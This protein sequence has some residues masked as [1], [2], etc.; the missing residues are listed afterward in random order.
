MRIVEIV[1]T[2]VWLISMNLLLSF[3]V[4]VAS[5]SVPIG[6]LLH[7]RVC[8]RVMTILI[9]GVTLEVLRFVAGVHNMSPVI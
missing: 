7:G 4:V 8:K 9:Y 3:D 6:H 5:M 1:R 2:V